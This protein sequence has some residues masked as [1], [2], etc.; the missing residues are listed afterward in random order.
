MRILTAL[1]IVLAFLVFLRV[2]GTIAYFMHQIMMFGFLV[3]LFWCVYLYL[4][5]R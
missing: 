5:R 1:A 3:V 4:R 2:A